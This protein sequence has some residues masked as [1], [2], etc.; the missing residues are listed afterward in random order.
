MMRNVLI[1]RLMPLTLILIA[2][3]VVIAL[4]SSFGRNTQMLLPFF[5]S[6]YIGG[7]LR[8]VFQ[9]QVWRLITPIFI[10]FGVIHILFNMLWMFDLGGV[11]ERMQGSRRL[12][13]LVG[14]TGVAGN[15]AQYWWSGP[16]FGGMSGVIYGLLG[17][18]WIQ[19]RFNPRAGLI[20]HQQIAIMMLA[21]FVLCWTGVIG[22]VANM[23]HTMGLVSGLILGWV[24]SP[25]KSLKR[26]R[27]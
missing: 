27:F 15:V 3:S 5:I 2:I 8:E 17:Y 12:G 4:V 10:H 20:L 23:A 7:G 16:D 18:V 1:V 13:V 6:E 24:Y 19:G 14:I 25:D 21:W 9:G 11:I 22:S 26:L